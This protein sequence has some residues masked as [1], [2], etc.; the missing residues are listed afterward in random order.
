MCGCQMCLFPRLVKCLCKSVYL[1]HRIQCVLLCSLAQNQCQDLICFTSLGNKRP[2]NGLVIGDVVGSFFF[3]LLLGNTCMNNLQKAHGKKM[4]VWK[5]L[6]AFQSFFFSSRQP[7]L[8]MY[9][10]TN[11][12]PCRMP[13]SFGIL[14]HGSQTQWWNYFKTTTTIK[15]APCV[16]QWELK[17]RPVVVMVPTLERCRGFRAGHRCNG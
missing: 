1:L 8:F 16:L 10:C 9:F 2:L 3:F 6:H 13:I 17:A 14:R 5:Q 15:R 12:L 4:H 7:Y 11:F